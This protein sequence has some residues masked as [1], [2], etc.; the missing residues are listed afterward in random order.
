M[1][2]DEVLVEMNGAGIREALRLILD[3]ELGAPNL[4]LVEE[5]EV[6]L[7][8]ALE[9]SM[10]RYLKEASEKCQIF[11][12]THSTNFLDTGA[13]KNVYLV[14]KSPWVTASLIDYEEAEHA[15]PSE[16]GLRLSSLFMFDRLLFVEGP[17]DEAILRELGATAGINFGQDGVGFVAMGSSRNFTHY[18]NQATI[19]FLTKRRVQMTFV[20]DRDE[21]TQDEVGKLVSRL[22][23]SATLHVLEKRE[24]E[25]Y[26]ATPKALLGFISEKRQLAGLAMLD[27]SV[28]EM[29]ALIGSKADSLR[30]IAVNKR[31]I[32]A[33]G[34]P[35]H[36]DRRSVVAEGEQFAASLRESLNSQRTQL[37]E[38]IASIDRQIEAETQYVDQAWESR[39]LHIVPGDELIDAICGE[40][41]VRYKKERDGGRL[42]RHLDMGEI[43]PELVR[44]LRAAAS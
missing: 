6:H 10:L 26:L 27:T 44:I 23:G 38:R 34:K 30:S 19:E 15:I 33:L 11:V 14:R 4:L 20:L 31:V 12:T 17:S 25:N 28:E 35:I 9:I 16:L 40:F 29:T 2:V 21:A 43:A 7:H 41:E 8:P 3:N 5:P 36:V 24:L 32:R 22:D 37:E 18:A 13:M 1:D 39:K 42:A